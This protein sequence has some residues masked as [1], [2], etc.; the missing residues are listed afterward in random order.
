MSKWVKEIDPAS[1]NITGRE[2]YKLTKHRA[3]T[4]IVFC[5]DPIDP[6]FI[7]EYTYERKTKKVTNRSVFIAKSIPNLIDFYIRQ[8]WILE[9]I[10][11][12]LDESAR[13]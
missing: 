7:F 13:I 11:E 6:W 5:E 1:T 4:T 3:K 9:K 10:E 2:V 8:G 12:A